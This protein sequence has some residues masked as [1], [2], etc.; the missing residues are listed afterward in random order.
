MASRNDHRL[1]LVMGSISR[2]HCCNCRSLLTFTA[3][4]QLV[5]CITCRST[6]NHRTCP[7]CTT[8]LIFPVHVQNVQCG[9]CGFNTVFPP[10]NMQRQVRA[11]DPTHRLL[12]C[13]GCR[14]PIS[15]PSDAPAVKCGVCNYVSQ[16]K[17]PQQVVLVMNPDM[18]ADDALVVAVEMQTHSQ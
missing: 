6:M 17:R 1:A 9:R 10:A 11:R 12:T 14:T 8:S 16:L 5:S 4:E 7:N 13:V 3:S 2:G 18:Q 15:F